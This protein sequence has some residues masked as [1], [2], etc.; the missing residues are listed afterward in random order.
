MK[1]QQKETFLQKIS[2]SNYIVRDHRV[3]G[4]RTLPGVALLDMI[5]RLS[6]DYIGTQAIELKQVLFKQPVVTAEHF[7]KNVFVTFT[8]HES[9]W[10]VTITSQKVKNNAPVDSA[11]D[12]NMECLLFLNGDHKP[13]N[14]F[15][16][17]AFIQRSARQWKMD[18]IYG[19]A[20]QV[21]IHHFEF[22]KTSG[23]IYQRT[24]EEIMRLQ[25]SELAEKYRD[26][27]YAHPAFL[28]GS[29]FGGSSF[30][31][32]G[33]QP[34]TFH[35][36]TP[37]IPFMIERFC[38]YQP[39]PGTIYTYT[40]KTEP[41]ENNMSAPLD[42]ISTDITIFNESGEV[43]AAFDKLHAKR[44]REPRSIKKLIEHAM[45]PEPL[46]RAIPH[47]EKDHNP[48]TSQPDNDSKH[49]I[50]RYLQKEVGNVLKK[51][52]DEIDVKSGF[53]DLG[54][55]STQLLGLVRELEQKLGKQLYP[56]L[57]FEYS[58]IHRLSDYF[59]ENHE[60]AFLSFTDR[61]EIADSGPLAQENRQFK[62]LY[63]EPAWKEQNILKRQ[64][65]TAERHRIIVLY[66]GSTTLQASVR[67]N[68]NNAD[69]VLLVSDTE[70]P[71]SGIE[72]KFTQLL[73][74]I[75]N[76]LQQ[77]TATEAL[78][79]VVADSNETGKYAHALGGLLKTAYLENPKLHSQSITIDRFHSLS[80][81]TILQLVQ[82]EALSH[83]QGAIDIHY[84]GEPLQ[85]TVKQ[86]QE[87]NFKSE[88]ILPYCKENGV[89]VITGG[90]GSLGLLIA[91]HIASQA[92][93]KLALIGRSKLNAAKEEQIHRLIRKGAEA[94]YLEADISRETDTVNAFNAIKDKFGSIT[95]I[96]HCAGVLKDQFIIRKD[97]SEIPDVFHPKVRGFWNVDNITRDEKLDFMV[98]FSSVS[99]I[100]GNLG[101]A[102]YAGANAF[103]DHFAMAR[104]EKVKNG[105]RHG[106]T[107]TINWPLWSEGGMRI[108]SGLEHI[109][110]SASGMKALPTPVGLE[111]LDTIMSQNKNHVI[112]LYGEESKIRNYVGSSAASEAKHRGTK[113]E[114]FVHIDVVAEPG[115]DP[116]KSVSRSND[117]AII[118]LSGR[119]PMANTLEQFYRNLKEGKD[120]ITSLPKDRWKNY[121]FTFDVEQFYTYGG[122]L[123]Q[124]DRFDPLFF[125]ISPRQAEMTDPQARLFLET[126]WEACEHAGF[127]QD[128]AEHY[129][130]SSDK[131]V[132][133]FAGV[134]WSHYELFGAEMTQRGVPMAF[135]VSPAS[136]PNLVSYCLNFH[137]PSMAIDTMC[138]SALTSIHL[139]CESIRK[140]ECQ[141]ALAGGVNLVTHPHK[142]MFLKQAQMLSSD[143]RCRSFGEGGDGYVPGE[144]V[145]A[146]LLTTLDRAEK[147]GYSVYGVIKGSAL[148][149]AGKTSGATVPDPVA[150]SEVIIE[151]LK[152]AEIDPRTISYIE[153]H[154]TGTSLGD[155]VEIQGLTKAYAKWTPDKQYCAI[156]SSKSNIGHLEAAAGIAG[157]TKLLLQFK[158]QEL[159]PSLH[160]EKLNPYI[161]FHDTPFYVEHKLKEWKRPE[162]EIYNKTVS[163]PRRAGLSSFGARGSNAHV[164]IEEYV[165]RTDA[166]R[167]PILINTSNPLLFVLSA[168]SKEQ[169]KIYAESVKSFI[170]SH[171]D[172]N[173]ANM[174]YT[175]QRGREAMDCRLAFV[176][177]SREALLKALHGYLENG[178]SAGVLTGQ[179][180][181]SKEGVS[182]FEADEDANGLL[183]IWIKKRKLKKIAEVWVKGLDIDWDQLY[184]DTKPCRI[185]LPTYPF[186]RERYWIPQADTG[187]SIAPGSFAAASSQPLNTGKNILIKEWKQKSVQTESA[188]QDGVLFI[189]GTAGTKELASELAKEMN[190]IRTV[191]VIHGETRSFEGIAADYY[192]VFAGEDLYQHIKHAQQDQKLL[193][194][195]D[196]TAFDHE[197]E[198]SPDIESGKIRFLQKLIEHDRSEGYKLLHVTYQLQACLT[199][200]TTL[201]GARS[202][203]LYRM[204]GAE[205]KQIQT[206]T[207][208]SDYSITQGTLLAKQIKAEFLSRNK[209]DNTECCYRNDQRYE[210]QLTVSGTDDVAP[211][212][213]HRTS[214]YEEHDVIV[215]TGGT[216]GIG[217]AI[218][219]HV[220]SQGVRNL[221]VMG[222]EDLPHPSEW[223]KVLDDREKPHVEEKLRRMQSFLDRGVTVHYYRTPLTDE[224]GI[225]AMV[226]AVHH[227]L[228]PITGVF[229]CAGSASKNPAFFKKPLPDIEAVCEPKMKGLATLHKALEKE[230]LDFFILFS[231]ISSV[232]PTLAAGQSDYAMANAYMDYYAQ[233]Q[234]GE[235]KSYFKSIQWP[236][237]GETGMAAGGMRTPAYMKTGL[238]PHSTAE[239]LALLDIIMKKPD[240]LSLPCI[241]VPGEFTRD[242]LLKTDIT[243]VHKGIGFTPQPALRLKPDAVSAQGSPRDLRTSI[244]QWLREIFRT[245]LK[246]TVDQLDEDKPF[247]EYGVDSIIL[248]QLAQTMQERLRKTI[249]P[250]LLLEHSTM[251]ALTDYFMTNHTEAFTKNLGFESN[252]AVEIIGGERISSGND[253]TQSVKAG[254]LSKGK[255]ISVRQ[256]ISGESIPSAE[257]IAVIGL[258][259]RFPGSST[260]EGYWDL[261]TKGISAI[262]PV[263]EKRWI[264]EDNRV[265]YGGWVDDIDL[266]DPEF[267]NIHE[268]DAAIMDPQARMILEESLTAIYDAGY[269]HKQLSG[270]KIGVYIGGRSQPNMNVNAVFQ[271]PNPI[272]GVGQNYLATNISRFFNF[273]GPSLVVDTACSSGITGMVLA[274]D[275]LRERRTDLALV[276][277]VNLLLNPL[278]HDMFA[279][280]NI[281]SKNGEFH[282][283]DKRSGGE[284]LGEGAGVVILKRLSDAIKEGNHIYGT[285]KAISVNNDGRTLGPGSPN[286]NAQKQVVQDALV[287][288]GKQPEDVGYIEVNGGGST[289]IDSIEIKALS[290]TYHLSNQA[291]TSCCIGSIKPNIGHLL[292][293]SGLAGF[294]RCIL[295]LHHK[296][297]PPFLSALDPFEYY[298]FSASRIRFIRDTIDWVVDSGKKRIAAQN[299]FPDGGTNC[300]V[301]LEEFVPEGIYQQR[302]FPKTAPPMTKKRFPLP[303]SS[304]S[305]HFS[306]SPVMEGREDH[307]RTDIHS[308]RELFKK[309]P[310]GEIEQQHHLPVQTAWGEIQ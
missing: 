240:T 162:I 294:I 230:P 218:A 177:S 41:A 61:D 231:S 28:D 147:E 48:E 35:D 241:V 179:V 193:G 178:S 185:S 50:M 31:L 286:I 272:L 72:D 310:R 219:E 242:Q 276:G 275:S 103:M 10:S 180:K 81:H 156:G 148:N 105:E 151:A 44:V 125:N 153:A 160:A 80:T 304:L 37:Y 214:N 8:P 288:S 55:D 232:A 216:R 224:E 9:H 213:H 78:V 29:T 303:V 63:F 273:R 207:M 226:D 76:Q 88:N 228:G 215:I 90:S 107:V 233:N 27:F 225:R 15:D 212:G 236:A 263:S 138:S 1:G 300:H 171:E 39:L 278:A 301:L 145:G 289:V 184:G 33:T 245:E 73:K 70:D 94:V 135:G 45:K 87:V 251:A 20:R 192:S 307:A 16:I 127:H 169:L 22:M 101:Q 159:F 52:P 100:L 284:V 287:L 290:E 53:Y 163:C 165:P 18:D 47:Q 123:D 204:L 86:L 306:F 222:R 208:D 190:E 56:T 126:A 296:Q 54:L 91:D 57:L 4:V 131:S 132:G 274:S 5:Y 109:M 142:Y 82:D 24:D 194:V 187:S 299:S 155:P 111:A 34:H 257:D 198:K 295:S 79:Q 183:R 40:K 308:I 117:I 235:G 210:P 92:K 269:E 66:D 130:P 136:I 23:R 281:L 220:V 26:K 174:A 291:L 118:G 305:K 170:E 2:H 292:L 68:I 196:I 250:A 25:L 140:R 112:V 77:K 116:N 84:K 173:L 189:M 265:D 237:W 158:Y 200:S 133:V 7:D 114:G 6:A 248:A 256:A 167:S 302:Y 203:G 119:Y 252:N 264:S 267:F 120:C 166:E 253:S 168:K 205:Y 260:K 30:R 258:S 206:T 17:A 199:A 223:K 102:D 115:K 271:A 121:P 246:L 32:E 141:Y 97:P 195:I 297:I 186:A 122:F 175:L 238:V 255:L 58:T 108:D 293:A 62:K 89:Y 217:A 106:K 209:E 239:G 96:F 71:P 38:I 229:H 137:G 95:G 211:E 280:R 268:N 75:Q 227:D 152:N 98:I 42:I 51:D 277:A 59:L 104:Q 139:A 65:A 262:R 149:H 259:C 270:Q 172:L 283:F 69:V 164:I 182:V 161:P 14:K 309:Q 266:F 124:I 243:P 285:I 201:Q 46:R 128:R 221:V 134:F 3:Y 154:G 13:E 110:Y 43:L 202:I 60:N 143:G 282:I 12:E 244:V 85:R 129:Y 249:G 146:V 188:A 234:A 181:K 261:L 279:S 150:Q 49:S 247:D 113:E 176:A 19:L 36:N 93:I 21:D 144:G 197:Y 74:V 191:P 64:D 67:Q 11:L 83:K 254:L 157:L 298:D 99:A